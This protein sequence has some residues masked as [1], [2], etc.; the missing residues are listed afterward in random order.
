[1]TAKPV[2]DY[3]NNLKFDYI[4]TYFFQRGTECSANLKAVRPGYNELKN[5]Q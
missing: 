4:E 2:A 3:I 1:M 5:G